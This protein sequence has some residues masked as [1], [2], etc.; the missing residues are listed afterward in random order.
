MITLQHSLHSTK[1][2]DTPSQTPLSLFLQRC[3]TNRIKDHPSK[4]TYLSASAWLHFE[5]LL[6]T[7]VVLPHFICSFHYTLFFHCK[8]PAALASSVC[9]CASDISRCVTCAGLLLHV[10][11]CNLSHERD[12]KGDTRLH[13]NL[14]SLLQ[15]PCVSNCHRY[16]WQ[17]NKKL[18]RFNCVKNYVDNG[19]SQAARY[20]HLH[21]LLWQPRRA[22]N[23]RFTK[24]KSLC[25]GS[26]S[27]K[28]PEQTFILLWQKC[29]KLT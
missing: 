20:L 22:V 27:Y 25:Y 4:E 7:M 2:M 9:I 19:A 12:M 21:A 6:E 13:S 15:R 18:Y 16:R 29:S 17:G 24:H 5:S 3:N 14:L 10:C 23:N 28:W 26:V 8:Q 11:K 1:F